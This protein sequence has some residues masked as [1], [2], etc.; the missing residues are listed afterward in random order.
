MDLT[1]PWKVEE[2]RIIY[3]VKCFTGV[4][5]ETASDMQVM[6]DMKELANKIRSVQCVPK[7]GVVFAFELQI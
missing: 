7:V 3:G 1:V 4:H 2:V 5:K 6:S